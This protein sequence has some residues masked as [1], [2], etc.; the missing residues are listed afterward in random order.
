[1]STCP[2]IKA[3][4]NDAPIVESVK[5]LIK[6]LEADD[7]TNFIPVTKKDLQKTKDALNQYIKEC[8]QCVREGNSDYRCMKNARTNLK[9]RIPLFA[10]NIYPWKNYDWDYGNYVTNNYN[11]NATGATINGSIPGMYNNALAFIKLINGLTDDP[12]PNAK[13]KAGI[14]HLYSDY[15]DFTY[16][17]TPNCITAQKVKNN[18]RQQKPTNDPF[19]NNKLDGEYS[20]S[21]YVKIGTCPRHDIKDQETCEGKGYTWTPN[22]MDKITKNILEKKN[23]TTTSNSGSCSQPRYGFVNNKPKTFLNGSKMKGIIPSLGSDFASLMPD[24]I[25]ATAMGASLSDSF[26]LQQCPETR[27]NFTN[28]NKTNISILLGISMVLLL[29]LIYYL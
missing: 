14:K 5:N 13:S 18:F 15:P 16:C 8:N 23:A 19:L 20:S 3:S 6:Q 27:E 26:I 24:K 12:I 17:T 10:N 2:S 11:T 29:L 9:R 4:C 7:I 21:Y 22:V 28:K 1:M 25:F